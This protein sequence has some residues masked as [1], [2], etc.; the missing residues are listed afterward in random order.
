MF[1]DVS[2]EVAPQVQKWW[3]KFW[4]LSALTRFL[5]QSMLDGVSSNELLRGVV[6]A[7]PLGQGWL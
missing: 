3:G 1:A 5:I 4:E 6:D 2:T 7:L